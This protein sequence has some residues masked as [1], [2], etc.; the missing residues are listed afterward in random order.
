MSRPRLL[1]V[2]TLA[3]A[4]GAQTFASALAGGLRE[5]YEIEVAAHGPDGAL[6]TACERLGLRF[7]HVE[8]LVRDPHPKHDAL[9][10]GELRLLAARVGPDV[11][12]I[13]SSKA[14]VLAR[15]ALAGTGVATV[16]TAHGWA[17]SGRTG[18]AGKAYAGAE[19]LTAPLTDAIVCVSRWDRGLALERRVGDPSRVHVIHN[20]IGSLGPVPDRGPWPDSPVL[21]CVARLA[22]P[23]DLVTLLAAMARP[24]LER[25]RLTVVGDGP[26]RP[27]IEA[28]RDRLGLQDR[29]E[30]LGERSDVPEQ[31]AR[32]DA[33]VLPTRWEG[34]P[35]SILE[36][37]AS[38]LPVVASRV[39]GIP[40]EVVDG[41]TGLLVERQDP[42]ALAEALRRLCADGAATRAM[43]AAGLARARTTFSLERMV[44][45]Y[46]ALF[47][48]LL[49]AR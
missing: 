6:P 10:V 33:F 11:V 9:A 35:Y 7:H 28:E 32:C 15:L 43:G 25:V 13:N 26:D 46:D 2:V 37:M 49:S 47:R 40:E 36:A 22:A 23:K 5:R 30:M 20:G 48:S 12:Q 24:G 31:L 3:E 1:I 41:H 29:V 42:D 27:E 21:G 39:G 14:G 18:K 44:D 38:G 17:F 16:Y 45:R 8:H 34:L 4:G 19:R